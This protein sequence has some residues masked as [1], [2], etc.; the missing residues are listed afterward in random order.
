[1]IRTTLI[2]T[3]SL[4]ACSQAAAAQLSCY[5]PSTC[6]LAHRERHLE[7]AV[8][9]KEKGNDVKG[10]TV[11]FGASSGELDKPSVAT[12]DNGIALVEWSGDPSNGEV[13]VTATA[14]V[15]G[16]IEIVTFKLGGTYLLGPVLGGDNQDWYQKR[17]LKDSIALR[18]T[19]PAGDS[20]Q[21]A[22]VIFRTSSEG[23]S[24]SLDTAWATG[25]YTDCVV[26]TRWKLADYVGV[27]RLRASLINDPKQRVDLSARSRATPWLGLGLTWFW[28]ARLVSLH[29]EKRPQ[30]FTRKT[31]SASGA[32]SI[33][34]S[35][36]SS[37]TVSRSIDTTRAQARFAPVAG[38]NWPIS[39]KWRNLRLFTAA[40][41]GDPTHDWFLGASI[42]Q[43]PFVAGWQHESVPIDVQVVVEWN[44]R[45]I[46]RNPD[47]CSKNF[48][49]CNVV[50]HTR[51]Y[52][53]GLLVSYN[54]EGALDKLVGVLLGK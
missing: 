51:F 53:G 1:M 20:C 16:V 5:S 30:H 24:V 19:V 31:L 37:V 10:R 41:L 2:L 8:R 40:D 43:L 52:G 28:S 27:Q 11:I 39:L 35:Y 49:T 50:T 26:A 48:A 23:G 33:E 4:L 9:V 44:R 34:V 3:I 18:L 46:L 54:V 22:A 42:I 29:T 32:D 17:Q 47:E 6:A 21:R 12:D 13:V 45:D 36:D 25:S 38:V 14:E 7:L 15:S